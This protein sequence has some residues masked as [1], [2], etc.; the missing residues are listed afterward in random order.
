[1]AKLVQSTDDYRFNDFHLHYYYDASVKES[2]R[3][4]YNDDGLTKEAFEKGNYEI[5]EFEFEQEDTCLEFEFEAE[6]GNNYKAETK[7]FNLIV[8]NIQKAPKRIKFGKKR[9][10]AF[11]Y[12]PEIKTLT[13]PLTWNTSKEK[14]LTI[15][16]KK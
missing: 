12:N 3:E 15:K 5:L 9:V 11:N 14:E 10:K 7:Q 8:H 4:F 1:M 2:E 13:I 6:I 16:L